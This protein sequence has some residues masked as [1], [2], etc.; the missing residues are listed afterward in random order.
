MTL[1]Q[2]LTILFGIATIALALFNY[3]NSVKKNLQLAILEEINVAED[4]YATGEEKKAYVVD[5]V[6]DLIPTLWKTVL[7][8]DFVEEL[9]QF[10]FD[11]VQCFA[12]K[13]LQDE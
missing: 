6:Y 5:K 7:K 1:P 9:V 12:N 11:Q 8:K 13:Q 2:F 4:M 3:Y 10:V